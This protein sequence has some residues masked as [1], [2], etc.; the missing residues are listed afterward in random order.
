MSTNDRRGDAGSELTFER[1]L[2]ASAAGDHVTDDA[3]QA[4][5]SRFAVALG[6][7]ATLAGPAAP[8]GAAGGKVAAGGRAA[9]DWISLGAV[10]GAVVTAAL[11]M[12]FM[13]R[14]GDTA[15][16]ARGG[17]GT[18]A[19]VAGTGAGVAG[20]GAAVGST[21]RSVTPSADAEE[22]TGAEPS[23]SARAAQ[24]APR[25]GA[26]LERRGPRAREL[27]ARAF[28]HGE[29]PARDPAGRS[30]TASSLA[31]EIALLDDA[32]RASSAGD[33]DRALAVLARYHREHPHCELRRE[34]DVLKLETLFL[35][36]DRDEAAR[37]AHHFLEAFPDDPH[38]AHVRT[39][40]Q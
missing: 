29:V 33:F 38:V 16:T 7:T 6:A 31:A 12:G 26:A 2:I 13:E 39:F 3:V 10:G 22:R 25:S 35:R 34:S 15:R 20:T 28:A 37:L 11:M 21:A 17:V 8:H 23:V 1:E 30:D 9:L 36:G 5:W 27:S 24:S 4:A 14:G 40:T 18:A 19:G 32:R